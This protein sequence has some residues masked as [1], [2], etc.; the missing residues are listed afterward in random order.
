MDDGPRHGTGPRCGCA[1]PSRA[2]QLDLG[3]LH[4]L[5]TRTRVLPGRARSARTLTRTCSATFIVVALKS[6]LEQ[7]MLILRQG[8]HPVQLL[9]Q[10]ADLDLQRVH[11]VAEADLLP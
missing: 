8:E 1:T 3:I 10:R 9:A 4:N 5:S 2:A 7:L 11:L 6:L